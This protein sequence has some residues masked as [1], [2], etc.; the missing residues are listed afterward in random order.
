MSTWIIY[1]LLSALFAA[2]VAILGKIGISQIDTTLAT[3]I[4]SIVM[5]IALILATFS[6]GKFDLTKID[7]KAFFFIFL[8]GLAGALSWIFY[9][10]ALKTGPA[11]GVAALDRLS[12]VFVLV[13][14]I[15]F[16]GESLTWKTGLGALL[17]SLGAILLSL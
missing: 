3:T 1:A 11:T 8:S 14:A 16:L 17:V 2:A 10:N 9:F 7:N 6:L 15:L 12:V 4:R 13:L 5:S